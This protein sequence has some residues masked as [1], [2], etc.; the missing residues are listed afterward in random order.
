MREEEFSSQKQEER[1]VEIKRLDLN[2]VHKMSDLP[3]FKS[4]RPDL[5]K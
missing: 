4:C 1:K 5:K 3:A 2:K